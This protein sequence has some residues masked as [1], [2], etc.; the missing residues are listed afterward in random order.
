MGVATDGSDN[1]ATRLAPRD[2][3]IAAY[4]WTAG[5]I[6]VKMFVRPGTQRG[7]LAQVAAQL[8]ERSNYG[9]LVKGQV[10]AR[11]PERW[12]YSKAMAFTPDEEI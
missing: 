3:R 1:A 4:L 7:I 6:H 9:H 11:D 10:F 12:W 2:Q 8:Q 5:Y